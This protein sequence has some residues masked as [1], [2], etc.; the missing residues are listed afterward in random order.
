MPSVLGYIVSCLLYHVKE[1]LTVYREHGSCWNHE[2]SAYLMNSSPSERNTFNGGLRNRG[3]RRV[4]WFNVCAI[5]GRTSIHL[6]SFF[7]HSSVLYYS[8]EAHINFSLIINMYS[9]TPF[10]T[11]IAFYCFF[12]ERLNMSHG[13]GMLFIFSCVYITSQSEGASRSAQSTLDPPAVPVILPVTLAIISTL[14]FT[15]S[16]SFGR[17]VI[18]KAKGTLTS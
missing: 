14:C 16:S 10:F 8:T 18:T 7:L 6:V 9:L 15:T 12:N 2:K 1:A 13:I 5:L 4:N 11:A 3:E 17:Y